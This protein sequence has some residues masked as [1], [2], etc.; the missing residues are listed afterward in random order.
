[1]VARAEDG[2]VD[3]LEDVSVAQIMTHGL[4]S[5]AA[6]TPVSEVASLMGD[7]RIHCIL[8]EADPDGDPQRWGVVSD[9]DL[10]GAAARRRARVGTIAEMPALT[11]SVDD[12]VARAVE[13]MN[14][15]RTAHLLV[16]DVGG[17]PV[18]VISTLDVVRVMAGGD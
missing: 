3:Y 16:L 11:V 5:C 6:R 18:G 10:V 15:Y 8:V 4:V 2:P 9:L 13:L 7:E 1:M 14:H 12:N 17:D